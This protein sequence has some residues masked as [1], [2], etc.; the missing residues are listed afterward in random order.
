MPTQTQLSRLSPSSIRFGG[1]PKVETYLSSI[2]AV[3]NYYFNQHCAVLMSA[4][5]VPDGVKNKAFSAIPPSGIT[6]SPLCESDHKRGNEL[7]PMQPN[8]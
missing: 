8:F 5:H 1:R 6:T 3:D 4:N 7:T 2:A